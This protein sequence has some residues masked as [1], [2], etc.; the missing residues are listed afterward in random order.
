MIDAEH[1]PLYV[2]FVKRKLK[3]ILLPLFV[4]AI[5][6]SQALA[7]GGWGGG[8]NAL[9]C[10]EPTKV[11]DR[12]ELI[13]WIRNQKAEQAKAVDRRTDYV[14]NIPEQYLTSISKIEVLDLL[15]MKTPRM[16]GIDGV[17]FRP[18][19]QDF[20]MPA[21]NETAPQYI[22]RIVNTRRKGL[23]SLNDFLVRKLVEFNDAARNTRVVKSLAYVKDADLQGL[24]I[25]GNQDLDN[26]LVLTLI[27]QLHVGSVTFGVQ[28]D[29]FNHKF[30]PRQSRYI[31]WLHEFAYFALK[32][33]PREREL[34][35]NVHHVRSLVKFLTDMSYSDELIK[36]R[37]QQWGYIDLADIP[38]I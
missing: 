33:H 22:S 14:Q 5:S 12:Y 32:T 11:T 18:N 4:S 3:L 19:E 16:N 38:M 2:R 28:N 31:T 36:K 6:A 35:T 25:E 9:V 26:C 27:S 23:P 1:K 29:L 20:L 24:D 17:S 21:D 34:G 8:G 10:F 13:A 30:H 7:V 37:L 15:E